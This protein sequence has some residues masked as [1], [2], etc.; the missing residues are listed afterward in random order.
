MARVRRAAYLTPSSVKSQR[1]HRDELGR[2]DM[3]HADVRRTFATYGGWCREMGAD[4]AALR[5]SWASGTNAAPATPES[6]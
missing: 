1:L 4:A 3:C 6:Q 5:E 2:S